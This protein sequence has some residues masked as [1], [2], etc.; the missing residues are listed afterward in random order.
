MLSPWKRKGTK[1]ILESA[2][3][4]VAPD[5][6]QA[7]EQAI[8]MAVDTVLNQASGFIKF[9][10][11]KGIEKSDTYMF[12]IHWETLEDHTVKFRESDLFTKWREI[13][14]PFFDATPEINH[15]EIN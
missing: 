5:N 13:I 7:F 9:Q 15:W 14:S 4:K 11:H 12:H 1:V 10:L 8:R 6:H 3:I 2:E